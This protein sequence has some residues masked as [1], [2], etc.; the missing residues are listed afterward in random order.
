MRAI[1]TATAVVVA[2]LALAGCGDQGASTPVDGQTT[3]AATT[4]APATTS[5]PG[6]TTPAADPTAKIDT[7]TQLAKLRPCV[8]GAPA[9]TYKWFVPTVDY[10]RQLGGD[11]F[12]VTLGVTP[13]TLIVFPYEQAAQLGAQNITDRLITLQQK[14]PSD[15]ATVAATASQVLGGNVLEV[16]TTGA[17]SAPVAS[18]IVTCVAASRA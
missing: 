12:T 2:L 15:Y 13:V 8:G 11:G 6:A 16:S 3:P 7:A 9:A 1:S 5:T 17:T 10:A 4:T 14:R 18:K